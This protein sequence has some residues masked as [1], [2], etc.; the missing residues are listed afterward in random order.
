MRALLLWCAVLACAGCYDYADSYDETRA[1]SA[2]IRMP[3]GASKRNGVALVELRNKGRCTGMLIAESWVLTARHCLRIDNRV[4]KVS[5]QRA[6]GAPGASVPPAMFW[7]PAGDI[8]LVRLEAPVRAAD[9]GGVTAI[10]RTM[11]KASVT[12]DTITPTHF[13]RATVESF[14]TPLLGDR[15]RSTSCGQADAPSAR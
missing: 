12:Q 9:F 7:S 14:I 6:G 15:P 4:T 3:T 5:W 8:G 2:E 13:A 1:A 11:K 10:K